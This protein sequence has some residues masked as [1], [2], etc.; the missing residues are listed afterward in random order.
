MLF[1]GATINDATEVSASTQVFSAFSLG[2]IILFLP[3]LA[4]SVGRG[5]AHQLASCRNSRLGRLE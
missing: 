1:A 3:S 5:F 2:S 4:A